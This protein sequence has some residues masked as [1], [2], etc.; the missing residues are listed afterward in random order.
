MRAP[1]QDSASEN[2]LVNRARAEAFVGRRDELAELASARAGVAGSGRGQLVVIAGDAGVGKSALVRE[3]CGQLSGDGWTAA[4]GGCVDVTAGALTYAALIGILRQLDHQLGREA[5][6]ELAGAGL[7]D[8]APLLPRHSGSQPAVGGHILERVLDF[9]V[10]LGEVAP[11]VVVVEDLHWADSSTRDLVAFVARNIHAARVLLIVTYR[12]D[13]LHRR[14][15]LTPLLAELERGDAPWIRLAGLTRPD[16]AE[17]VARTA[18]AGA[19]PSVPLLLGRTGGN[20]FFIEELLAAPAPVTA[21]P[22]GLRGVL[23]ARLR[24]LPDPVLAVLRPASVLGQGFTE[25]LLAAATGLPLPQ[26]EDALRRAVDHNILRAAAA[27]TW[28][29]SR[30]TRRSS[31]RPAPGGGRW[32]CTGKRPATTRGPWTHP[33]GQPAGR[34]WRERHRTRPITS[35]PRW[36]CGSR[37]RPAATRTERT[38]QRCCS[39]PRKPVPPRARRCGREPWPWQRPRSSPGRLTSSE[40][41]WPT[42]R[43]GPTRGWQVKRWPARRHS[44]GR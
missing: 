30:R 5:I 29:R 8:L 9:L 28:R 26:I 27:A 34:A 11:A 2:D 35:K 15:P 6:V 36:P 16:V 44:S 7:G 41:R 25:D 20:P 18:G 4:A 3:F 17:L 23:L 13:D 24:D 1:T 37:P 32:R 22:E 14:H 31:I 10:R 42:C 19:A 33:S 40:L 21:L 43:S 38:G 12:A 39:R